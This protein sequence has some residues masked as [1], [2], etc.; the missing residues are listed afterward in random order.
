MFYE[1]VYRPDVQ[2]FAAQ[3][4][5]TVLVPLSVKDGRKKFLERAIASVLEQEASTCGC[6]ISATAPPTGRSTSPPARYVAADP[7]VHLI[8]QNPPGL[9][10]TSPA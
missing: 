10:V 8:L 2:K 1:P 6:E 5:P 7:R 4:R 3:G 9:N